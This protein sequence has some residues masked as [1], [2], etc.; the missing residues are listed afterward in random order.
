MMSCAIVP[1]TISDNAVATRSQ[2]ETSVAISARPSQSA[3]CVQISVIGNFSTLYPS[4]PAEGRSPASGL[5]TPKCA[6]MCA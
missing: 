5:I 3:A 2:M 1:T 4:D 6:G